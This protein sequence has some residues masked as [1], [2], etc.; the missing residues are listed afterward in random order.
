MSISTIVARPPARAGTSPVAPAATVAVV[1]AVVAAAALAGIALIAVAPAMAAKTAQPGPEF[2]FALIGDRTGSATPGIWESIVDQIEMFR[3][4]FVVS[5]GDQIEGYTEDPAELDQQ[6]TGVDSILARFSVPFYPCPGNHD[7]TTDGMVAAWK[8][9][10]HREPCYSFDHQGVHFVV[11]DT[12]RWETSEQWMRESGYAD[13]LRADLEKNRKA[14][15]TVA[16]FHKPYWYN[17][18]ADGREDL[19]HGLFREHGVDYVFNGHFHNYGS[20]TYDGI[21]YTI[22]GSSGGGIDGVDENRGMFFQ[23]AW[24]AVR[25]DSLDWQVVRPE[26]VLPER[27]VPV[28][29]LK[30]LDDVATRHIQAEPFDPSDPA[31]MG[32]ASCAVSIRNITPTPWTAE[33][34]WEPAPGWTISPVTASLPLSPDMGVSIPFEAKRT[35]P[36]YPLPRLR[37]DY[38]YREGHVYKYDQ[39]L[40]IRRTQPAFHLIPG[41]TAPAID[42]RLDDPCWTRA[43]AATEFSDPGGNACVIEPTT[44]FFAQDA[45]N[46]YFAARC[47]QTDGPPLVRALERDAAV[48]RDDCVG[49]FLC[50]DPAEKTVYQIYFNAAGTVFD[51]KITV[52][53]PGQYRGEMAKWNGEY[54]VATQQVAG[55]WIVEATIPF[56]VLGT[57]APSPGERWRVNFRRKEMSRGSYADWQHPLGYEPDRFGYLLFG[58]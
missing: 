51:Q 22:L 43:V 20:G 14:R 2:R 29:D 9:R 40:A 34:R 1:L 3:P 16:V 45:S 19:L 23:Y 13:W 10:R 36:F 54:T 57:A 55:E 37:L 38:P 42:G 26:G 44:V 33:L 25:G 4:A 35:G 5:V 47:T 41:A 18:I 48:H 6:W 39:P 53:A 17:T 31:Q 28:S 27:C 8:A 56:A 50:A 52:E 7:I 49:F 12:G 30:F 21:R 58:E 24:C 46:L 11:L 32:P 15:L